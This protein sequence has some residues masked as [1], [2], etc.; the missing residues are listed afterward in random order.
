MRDD[1]IRLPSVVEHLP[2]ST[3]IDPRLLVEGDRFVF[4]GKAWTVAEVDENGLYTVADPRVHFLF[5]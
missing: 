4:D 3:L 2:H 5:S 1:S